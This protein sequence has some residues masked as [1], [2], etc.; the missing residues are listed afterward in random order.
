MAY[1]HPAGLAKLSTCSVCPEESNRE[2][3]HLSYAHFQ[4]FDGCMYENVCRE[5]VSVHSAPCSNWASPV[6]GVP[7]LQPA[8]GTQGKNEVLRL[9]L[10]LD[11]DVTRE[12]SH[13][14]CPVC[15]CLAQQELTALIMLSQRVWRHLSTHT[16]HCLGMRGHRWDAANEGRNKIKI[17]KKI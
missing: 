3:F 11:G 1:F 14:L 2:C 10:P 16:E 9:Y 6:L 5:N 15:S 8:Q 17:N 12:S 13:R 7:T 4:H